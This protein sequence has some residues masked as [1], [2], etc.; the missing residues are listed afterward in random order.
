[1]LFRQERIGCDCKPFALLKF[2][3]MV[4]RAEQLGRLT[5][6][7]DP[8]ITRVGRF[9]RASKLDEIPQ[10]VNVVLGDMQFV[11]PRPEVAE[12]V[13]LYL[14]E[15]RILLIQPPGIT[16]PASLAFRNEEEMLDREDRVEYYSGNILPAKI[17]MSLE[18]QVQRTIA[19]DAR[20]CI[21]TAVVSAFIPA[22]LTEPAR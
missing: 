9:L 6:G 19:A 20:L 16:D 15:Y 11:G 12:Y 3:T 14:A 13:D 5:R 1:M 21:K 18:Y 2:R 10:L 17:K 7:L 4:P 22:R 8:R